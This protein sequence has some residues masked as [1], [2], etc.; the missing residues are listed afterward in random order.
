MSESEIKKHLD[1][2]KA[3]EIQVTVP[4]N[5]PELVSVSFQDKLQLYPIEG[6]VKLLEQIDSSDESAPND[7]VWY[8]IEKG[9]EMQQP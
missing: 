5:N 7:S 3:T 2:L 9:M 4:G 1:R 6:V 8:M